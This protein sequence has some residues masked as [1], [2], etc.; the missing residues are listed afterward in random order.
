MLARGIV[1]VMPVR[2]NRVMFAIQKLKNALN[3]RTVLFLLNV[4]LMSDTIRVVHV[5]ALV[6]GQYCVAQEFVEDLEIV[7]VIRV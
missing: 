6:I 2:V 7:T 4:G 3:Q 1:N 5:L